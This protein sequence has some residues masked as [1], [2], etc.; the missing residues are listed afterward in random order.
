APPKEASAPVKPKE[1]SA[2]KPPKESAPPP[3]KSHDVVPVEPDKPKPPKKEEVTKPS[4]GTDDG[5]EHAPAKPAA[6]P[7][8]AAG[9]IA[10]GVGLAAPAGDPSGVPSLNSAAFPYDWYRATIVNLIRS[11]WRRPVTPGLASPLRC[12][13]SFLISKSGAL[14]DIAIAASSGFGTLDLSALRAVTEASPLPQLPYQYT[15]ESV[16]GELVFELTP[17]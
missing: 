14:S 12:S 10:E 15:S 9:P 11:R 1:T 6:A 8:P 4:H 17:D 3:K 5:E 13:V 16:R 2:P 7:S